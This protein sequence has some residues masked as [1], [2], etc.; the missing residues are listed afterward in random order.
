MGETTEATLREL[1]GNRIIISEALNQLDNVRHS[2]NK[3]SKKNKRIN[4][5]ISL[6]FLAVGVLYLEQATTKA[7]HEAE[8]K[9]LK[10]ELEKMQTKGE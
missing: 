4:R 6:L 9:K 5:R 1:I 2:V 3:V 7:K 8:I 10:G